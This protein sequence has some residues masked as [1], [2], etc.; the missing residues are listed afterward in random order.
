MERHEYDEDGTFPDPNSMEW[1]GESLRRLIWELEC[2]QKHWDSVFAADDMKAEEAQQDLSNL[3]LHLH[4]VR[5]GTIAT[6]HWMVVNQL[7]L[8]EFFAEI[9]KEIAQEQFGIPYEVVEVETGTPGVVAYALQPQEVV[10]PDS[11]EGM[12]NGD[13][14]EQ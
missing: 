12:D 13:G 2:C 4:Q 7:I 10:V 1:I 5:I 9:G 14:N 8:P 11:L 6:Q 3:F